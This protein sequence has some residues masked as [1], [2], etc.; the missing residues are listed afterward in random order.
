MISWLLN[1]NKNTCSKHDLL[2]VR[3]CDLICL[4]ATVVIVV[5]KTQIKG[6]ISNA[7]CIH[8]TF[9]DVLCPL[10]VSDTPISNTT[11]QNSSGY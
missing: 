7:H 3:L 8:A 5:V 11:L 4:K 2:I 10:S 9:K 6:G 1:K